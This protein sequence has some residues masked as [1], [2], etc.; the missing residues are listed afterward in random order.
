[1]KRN[2]YFLNLLHSGLVAALCL[3]AMLVRTF[4]PSA[5]IPEISIP[6][7]VL[8]TVVSLTAEHYLG[9]GKKRA[10][11][12][13]A[14]IGAA[15]FALL[16]LCAGLT[17]SQPV[18]LLFL[19]GGAVFF[20]TTLLYTSICDRMASG[21]AAKLAPVANALLLFLAAQFFQGIL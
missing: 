1:M 20:L 11:L 4:A 15:S 12:G 19:C 16:P 10:W 3:W 5:L 2:I 8:V 9:G 6:L 17:L 21:P 13:S 18:W 14:L 7:M